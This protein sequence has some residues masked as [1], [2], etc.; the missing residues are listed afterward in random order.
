MSVAM[1]DDAGATVDK[2]AYAEEFNQSAP[3][4]NH[5]KGED[6]VGANCYL[7]SIVCT[8]TTGGQ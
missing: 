2:Q 6:T 8:F 1:S 4:T 7:N 3:G 5:D